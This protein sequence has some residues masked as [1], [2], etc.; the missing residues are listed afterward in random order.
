MKTKAKAIIIHPKDTV[1][2]ALEPLHIGVEIP[3]KSGDRTE[4][5]R[6]VSEIPMGHK[7]ALGDIDIGAA[8]IKY[9]EP[10]GQSKVKIVKGEHVHIHNVVSRPHTREGG[11]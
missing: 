8:V 11:Q 7:F 6:L 2:T 4:K 10:I 1:A 9:G 5:V 3:V